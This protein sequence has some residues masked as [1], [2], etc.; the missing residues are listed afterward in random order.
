MFSAEICIMTWSEGGRIMGGI[1]KETVL[2]S[3]GLGG[4]AGKE[5]GSE[6]EEGVVESVKE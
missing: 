1:E 3:I 6:L 4:V 2:A 5:T